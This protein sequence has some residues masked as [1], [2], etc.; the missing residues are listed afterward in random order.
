MGIIYTRLPNGRGKL[1]Y[2]LIG[3]SVSLCLYDILYT[4]GLCE[5]NSID[6]FGPSKHLFIELPTYYGTLRPIEI[7]TTYTNLRS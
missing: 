7:N 5:C 4:M 1:K 2:R 3:K 6:F